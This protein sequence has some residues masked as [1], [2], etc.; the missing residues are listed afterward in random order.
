MLQIRS[1]QNRKAEFVCQVVIMDESNQELLFE[2]RWPGVIAKAATGS[3]GFGYDPI[4]VAEGQT[5][6]L[7][8][9]G[10]GFKNQHSHRRKALEPFMQKW[11]DPT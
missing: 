9:L 4:F 3:Y 7:A 10:P 6:T 1:P 2:G 8:E 5:Q 11:K